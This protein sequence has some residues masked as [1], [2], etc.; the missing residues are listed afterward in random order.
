M[1]WGMVWP[2]SPVLYL[3]AFQE[4]P[5]PRLPGGSLGPLTHL[6]RALL[7]WTQ[8]S[9]VVQPASI[10]IGFINFL[11]ALLGCNWHAVMNTLNGSV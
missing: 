10:C 8:A 7:R 9:V 4:L 1:A 11:A 6:G 3:E 2:L 5:V